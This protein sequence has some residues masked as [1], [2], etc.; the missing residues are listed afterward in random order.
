MA[1]IPARRLRAGHR[2]AVAAIDSTGELAVDSLLSELAR[3]G[4][5]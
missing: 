2:P 1:G 5:Y 3:I 4:R